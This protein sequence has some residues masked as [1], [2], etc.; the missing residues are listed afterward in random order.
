M[1]DDIKVTMLPRWNYEKHIY[2]P[3]KVSN[4]VSMYK[5]NLDDMVDCAECGKEIKFGDSYTSLRI[6]NEFGLGYAV[7]DECYKKEWDERRKY[8]DD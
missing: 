1:I 2:E 6:H 3:Y 4:N 5:E 8:R 7:C